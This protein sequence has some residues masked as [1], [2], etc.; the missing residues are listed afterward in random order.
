MTHRLHAEPR[1]LLLV[2]CTT[3]LGISFIGAAE[4]GTWLIEEFPIFVAAPI[5]IAIANRFP[6]TPLAYRLI[7]VHA[8][9]RMIGGHYTYAKVPLGF[10]V[11]M[12]DAI[13]S[14]LA[15]TRVHD[16]QLAKLENREV[17]N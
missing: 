14:Q 7:F 6:S 1:I 17:L 13:I 16:R 11:A 3:S 12:W 15:L 9:I 2:L 4:P 8:L 5:L 10:W